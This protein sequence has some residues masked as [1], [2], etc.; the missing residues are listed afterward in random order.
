MKKI[1]KYFCYVFFVVPILLFL[2]SDFTEETAF[3]HSGTLPKQQLVLPIHVHF[4]SCMPTLRRSIAE[5]NSASKHEQW[6]NTRE[7]FT[8][9]YSTTP[10]GVSILWRRTADGCGAVARNPTYVTA[11]RLAGL[12]QPFRG[13]FS[14]FRNGKTACPSKSRR[15]AVHIRTYVM[16]QP[17]RRYTSSI[18]SHRVR[19]V[20][21]LASFP[22]T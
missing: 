8:C 1:N 19:H 10:P 13:S 11:R 5:Q 17:P 4:S 6:N 2:F 9:Q 3:S 14:N 20:A 16:D 12:L 18:I 7:H 21:A 15:S 22:V